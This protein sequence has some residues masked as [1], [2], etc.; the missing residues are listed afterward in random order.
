MTFFFFHWCSW[1]E[2]AHSEPHN[3]SHWHTRIRAHGFA[4]VAWAL[5]KPRSIA[6]FL[7]CLAIALL[8]YAPLFLGIAATPRCETIQCFILQFL[9]L[10]RIW[11][12]IEIPLYFGSLLFCYV[13]ATQWLNAILDGRKT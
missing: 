11:A 1:H 8:A 10:V 3:R 12:L 9:P 6:P 7:L 4:S 2:P 5:A 13:K